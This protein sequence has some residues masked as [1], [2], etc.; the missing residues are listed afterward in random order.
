MSHIA[1]IDLHIKDMSALRAACKDLGLV[2]NEGQKTYKWY[3][4]SYGKVPDGFTKDDLGKCDHAISIENPLDKKAY[5]V[6]V[7]RRRDG[8]PGFTL[9]WDFW[10]G[11]YG[12]EAK[13]GKD[14][15]KLKQRYATHVAIRAARKQG[16]HV[17]ETM[18]N[19]KVQLICSR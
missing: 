1:E 19:G 7:V 12:L 15:Q 3:G 6:G 10:N 11:G 4:Q 8:K 17:Q 2:L 14:A 9:M 13:I 16:L 18:K 5:E